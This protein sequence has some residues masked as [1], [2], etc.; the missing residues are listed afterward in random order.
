MHRVLDF[1]AF[2]I[3]VVDGWEDITA[4]LDD[5]DAPLTV[6]DPIS[7]VG[8]LQFSPA[9]FKGGRLPRVGPQDLRSLLDE[10]ASGQGWVNPFDRSAY[11]G[12]V[13]VEGASF[14]SGEDLIRVW[15]ASDGRSVMLVTYVCEWSEREREASQREMSVRS[16]RFT[17]P[18]EN[19]IR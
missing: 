10:F 2:S 15:Y 5:A 17:M 3:S 11:S 7:G 12:G 1:D 16:I 9:I 18:A 19:E 8:A 14:R 6:A 4:T 13:T